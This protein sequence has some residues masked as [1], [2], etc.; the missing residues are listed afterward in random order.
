MPLLEGLD[1]INEDV[2]S[3]SATTSASPMRPDDMFGKL[4]SI[5]D[6]LMWRYFE[7]LSFR[8]SWPRWRRCSQRGGR[9]ATRAT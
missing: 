1:G 2:A 6:E 9:A 5:S 7:L 8:S 3:R 4:M